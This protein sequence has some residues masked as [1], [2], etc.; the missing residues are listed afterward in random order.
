MNDS[1]PL[2]IESSC[3]SHA[4]GELFLHTFDCAKR[5]LRPVVLSVTG[6]S[7]QPPVEDPAIRQAVDAAMDAAEK[8]TVRVSG[9]MIFPY[10][11]WK[12]RGRP[13]CREFSDFC[14]D[15]VVP[16]LKALDKR[17]RYGTYF[18]R[19]MRFTG[20][21]NGRLH[22]VN[23]LEFVIGLLKRP[24]RSRHSALQ[25]AC[26]DPAKDHTGQAVRGFPCLQQVSVAQNDDGRLAI[27]AYYPAQYI[28]DRAYGNYLGLCHLG[29]FLAHETNL[30]F[31][32]LNCYIG[33]PILGDVR[34]RNVRGLAD[35]VRAQIH[36]QPVG[37]PTDDGE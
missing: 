18:E 10:E 24:R 2:V 9:L 36:G 30:E 1:T 7:D 5:H 32:Q 14:V 22:A 34:K 20:V 12:R 11:M 13:S 17:N 31:A 25:I 16:R 23:Q 21:R 8:N 19:M 33:Q 37:E 27:N 35:L 3:I 15:Q 28:F 4:W 26:F 29:Q 6:L